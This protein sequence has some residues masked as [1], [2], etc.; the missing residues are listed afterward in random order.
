MQKITVSLHTL[1][2]SAVF[3]SQAFS[4]IGCYPSP[5]THV[6]M[7]VC[8]CVCPSPPPLRQP[9]TL[10]WTSLAGWLSGGY[11]DYHIQISLSHQ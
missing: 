11:H 6:Y 2:Q 7:C 10:L 3:S 9:Q 5:N 8:V 1:R 4:A